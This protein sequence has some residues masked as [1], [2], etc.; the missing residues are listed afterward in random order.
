MMPFQKINPVISSQGLFFAFYL[1]PS[2][3][4]AVSEAD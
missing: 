4:G 3:E 2:D 1:A